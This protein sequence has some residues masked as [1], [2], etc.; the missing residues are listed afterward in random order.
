MQTIQEP[1]G[2]R[3]LLRSDICSTHH[4]LLKEERVFDQPDFTE[5]WCFA[6]GI[7]TYAG[8]NADYRSLVVWK[9]QSHEGG[10]VAASWKEN[11][12]HCFVIFET[13]ML[14]FNSASEEFVLFF[15]HQRL[16]SCGHERP[17]EPYQSRAC[18]IEQWQRR[19]LRLQT[20]LIRLFARLR[21][22]A[23]IRYLLD[24]S[25]QLTA[26]RK[27]VDRPGFRLL[28]VGAFHSLCLRIC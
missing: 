22:L 25:S 21:R 7:S 19:T 4:K 27:G 15:H 1:C 13:T 10:S 9:P 20:D 12:Q 2:S 5:L 26:G 3:G 14:C 8:A 17:R 28:E 11:H 18:H 23:E 24:I 6:A 16:E